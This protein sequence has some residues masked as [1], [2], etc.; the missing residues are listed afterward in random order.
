MLDTGTK[1]PPRN[2]DLGRAGEEIAAPES[3]RS[4]TDH[5]RPSQE[6]PSAAHR[7]RRRLSPLTFRILA[8]NL[9]ALALVAIGALVLDRYRDQLVEAELRA[10]ALQAEVLAQSLGERATDP[11]TGTFSDL[12]PTLVRPFVRRFSAPIQA[13]IRVF[14][15]DGKVIADSRVLRGPGGVVQISPLP[16]PEGDT[17]KDAATKF[18]DWFYERVATGLNAL[19]AVA[20]YREATTVAAGDYQEVQS[21][22]LG[23]PDKI[24]RRAPDQGLI[25]TVAAPVRGY[26]QILGALMLQAESD[27]IAE[28]IKQVRLEFLMLFLPAFLLVIASS[29]WL[30][31]T[32][33]RPVVKLALA[34][35][36]IQH[37]Q[38]RSMPLPDFSNRKDEIG[39]LSNS[40]RQMTESLWQRMDATERFAADVS[41][42][43]KNPLTSLRSAVETAARLKDPEPQKKL[44]AII[45]D[46]VQRL[47][48]LISDISDASRLDAELSRG[49]MGPVSIAGML[50]TI[51]D[52]T[53]AGREEDPNAVKIV[54]KLPQGEPLTCFG[55]EGRLV[56]VFRNIIE[57]ARSFSPDQGTIRVEA[58]RETDRE[59]DTILIRI[60][61][62]GPGVPEGN[63]RS[64][65]ERFY[66]ERPDS[67]K[68]GTH[69]G[70][71]LSI[72]KQIISAHEGQIW[73]EN[74]KGR[75]GGVIGA[76]FMIRLPAL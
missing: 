62:D 67:E 9:V 60:D 74:R 20:D 22:L 61:D 28:S 23:Q 10:M 55:L 32:I 5:D 34:A 40:L 25:L 49:E 35:E 57:N 17:E 65:F 42:E 43:I 38:G 64:I 26:R 54:T 11:A 47:D 33:T 6:T 8:I 73:A 16:P 58:W 48:R 53:N 69:S 3:V 56:Q 72:S 29:I 24:L 21:A 7:R 51:A 44:M 13:R 50:N 30:A 2:A 41:H 37:G 14:D 45:L 1:K 19:D 31:R 36:Q 12:T 68:F 71:G 59:S 76:R 63:L 46:D 70:L 52:L 66:S 18:A 15:T 27:E 4:V 75:N 39:D